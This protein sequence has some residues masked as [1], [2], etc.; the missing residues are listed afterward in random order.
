MAD[1][2]FFF[3]AGHGAQIPSV[4]RDAEVDRSLDECLVPYDFDWSAA[5]AITDDEFCALYSQL[6]YPRHG[7]QRCSIAATRAA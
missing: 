3:Y 5:R 7:S 1:E 6:P 2:L 4:G